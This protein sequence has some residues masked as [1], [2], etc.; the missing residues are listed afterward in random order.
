MQRTPAFPGVS[1]ACK[2]GKSSRTPVIHQYKRKM[3]SSDTDTLVTT[4]LPTAHREGSRAYHAGSAP[5]ISR[6]VVAR[7]DQN[8][9]RP[10]LPCLDIFSEMLVLSNSKSAER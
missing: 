9:Q 4:A 5:D 8:F 1:L 3:L 7:S 10:I 2:Q 6:R